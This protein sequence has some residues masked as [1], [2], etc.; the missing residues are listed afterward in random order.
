[1]RGYRCYILDAENHIL[2]AHDIDC[3][4]D[5]QARARAESLLAQDPYYRSAEVWKA[6]RRVIRLERQAAR[7]AQSKHLLDAPT[8][9]RVALVISH[10]LTV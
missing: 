2:Q 5:V 9:A 8:D 6:A 3:D 10:G 7:G 4:S 1:M